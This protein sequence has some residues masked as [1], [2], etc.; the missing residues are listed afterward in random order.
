MIKKKDLKEYFPYRDYDDEELKYKY[1]KI[2]LADMSNEIDKKLF[3]K[4]FGH[5]LMN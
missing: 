4:I 1:F 5:A 2:K 3:E